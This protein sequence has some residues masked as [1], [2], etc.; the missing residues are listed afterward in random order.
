[1]TQKSGLANAK[2]YFSTAD[3]YSEGQELTGRWR[4]DG[5]RR[6]GLAGEMKQADWDALCENRNPQT[7][8]RLT[9]R[10]QIRQDNRV[11]FQ[12]PCAQER[13]A[14]LWHDARRTDSGCFPRSRRRHDAQTWKPKW[15]PG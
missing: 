3:Y 4:G 13:V 15:L 6:L 2:N 11:R 1:M 9:A 14:A 7:G 5:A 12:L 8:E 10:T